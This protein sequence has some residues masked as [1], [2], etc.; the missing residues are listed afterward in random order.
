MF[1]TKKDGEDSWSE[2]LTNS[3]D[4]GRTVELKDNKIIVT[5]DNSNPAPVSVSGVINRK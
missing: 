5:Y 3:S 1:K 2:S 4:A